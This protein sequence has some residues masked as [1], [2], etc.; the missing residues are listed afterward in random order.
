MK[1]SSKKKSEVSYIHFSNLNDTEQFI[2]NVKK[3][4]FHLY[5]IYGLKIKIKFF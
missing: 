1:K 3:L 5:N 2:E 4:N